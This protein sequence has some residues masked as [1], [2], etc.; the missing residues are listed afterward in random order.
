M[1]KILIA[2]RSPDFLSRLSTVFENLGHSVIIAASGYEAYTEFQ[3]HK[4]IDAMILDLLMPE[5]DGL[6][7]AEKIKAIAPDNQTITV[8]LSTESSPELKERG[9]QIGIDSWIIKHALPENLV[10]AVEGM[11]DDITK[12]NGTLTA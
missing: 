5:M 10:I 11:I 9:E 2:D 1:A 7:T 12:S 3:K 4:K 8:I 6:T